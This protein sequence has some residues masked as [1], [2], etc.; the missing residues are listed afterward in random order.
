MDELPPEGAK[1]LLTQEACPWLRKP[2]E[3]RAIVVRAEGQGRA[4]LRGWYLKPTGAL[5]EEQI[6]VVLAGVSVLESA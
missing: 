2:V 5:C 3:F 4:V 1:L 6:D